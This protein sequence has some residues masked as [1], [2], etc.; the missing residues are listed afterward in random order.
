MNNHSPIVLPQQPKRVLRAQNCSNCRF[1]DNGADG[2]L[3]RFNPP[4]VHPILAMTPQGPQML[5]TVAMQ[6]TVSET[7]W[8]SQ[9]KVRL[10]D[11]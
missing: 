4:M 2:M 5:G 1:M 10:A 7:V 11:G 3:C 8:C 6:P 9:H